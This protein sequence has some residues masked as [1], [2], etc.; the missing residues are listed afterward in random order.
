M[1]FVIHVGRVT[2]DRARREAFLGGGIEVLSRHGLHATERL[3]IEALPDLPAPRDVLCLENRTGALACAVGH[4]RPE[5]AVRIQCVDVFHADAARETIAGA[6]ADVAVAC[7]PHVA[8]RGTLDVVL[9]PLPRGAVPGE[10]AADLLQE[11]RLALRPGGVCVAA[12]HDG[13]TACRKVFEQLFDAVGAERHRRHG[14]VCLRGRAG[15]APPRLRDR[16]ARFTMSLPGDVAV[17]LETVPGV[18]AHRRPDAGG[19]ALAECA[20]VEP[21]ARVLDLGCGSGAVG[22]ALA[23][24]AALARLVLVDASSRAVYAARRNAAANAI[25]AEVALTAAG[26][27]EPGAF[28]VVVANPPYYSDY[29]IAALFVASAATCLCPGGTAWFVARGPQWYP[30]HL[31]EAVGPVDV[32]TRRGY[33]VFRAVKQR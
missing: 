23:R 12:L 22:L 28:D 10:L 31:A 27:H 2:P 30:E 6:R 17:A 24:K 14:V 19:L 3:L 9:L 25:D 20:E 18:F 8:A 16:S 26:R 13:D 4:C 15:A 11:A 7:A 32:L 21:G 29:R 5:A 33:H 1:P